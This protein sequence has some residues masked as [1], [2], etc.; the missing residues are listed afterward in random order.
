MLPAI[1]HNTT[2]N[3]GGSL[4]IPLG[5]EKHLADGFAFLGATTNQPYDITAA[6]VQQMTDQGGLC[7][8]IAAN[9]GLKGPIR[10]ALRAILDCLERLAA[11]STDASEAE[12]IC[13]NIMLD[14]HRDRILGRLGCTKARFQKPASTNICARLQ[15]LLKVARSAPHIQRRRNLLQRLHKLVTSINAAET[16]KSFSME[17]IA[18]LRDVLQSSFDLMHNEDVSDDA[19]PHLRADIKTSREYRELRALANYWRFCKYLIKC[20]RRY[21]NC[22]GSID[23]MTL[24]PV[25]IKSSNGLLRYVHAEI[26]IVT[27][28]EVRPDRRPRY[29][30][31]SK[32]PCFLCYCFVRAHAT[33]GISQ[34][35]GE[36]YEMWTVP[37]NHSYSDLAR[38]TLN[39]ALQLTVGDIQRAIARP[40]GKRLARPKGKRLTSLFQHPTQTVSKLLLDKISSVLP[41]TLA[42][43]QIVEQASPQTTPCMIFQEHDLPIRTTRRS[44]TS[45]DKLGPNSASSVG[46]TTTPA[47]D[48]SNRYTDYVCVDN[49]ELFVEVV[50]GKKLLAAPYASARPASPEILSTLPRVKVGDMSF[51]EEIATMTV[52]NSSGFEMVLENDTKHYHI[53]LRWHK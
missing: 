27:H 1:P 20:A 33:Y 46:T 2:Q 44:D 28:F 32:K 40:K 51:G 48:D 17:E 29:V 4:A 11:R 42:S 23:L 41:S 8:V 24:A 36:I 18:A 21:K 6:A 16:S 43:S 22:F 52:T 45:S 49:L 5:V 31:S 9:Q 53:E 7:L 50:H 3:P 10:P 30:S 19:L 35:H 26:Q 39:Q 15:K 14:M 47:K 25:P 12:L 34:S 37:E 38:D 13:R